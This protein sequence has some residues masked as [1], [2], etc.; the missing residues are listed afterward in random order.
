MIPV[1]V[2]MLPFGPLPVYCEGDKYNFDHDA[3]ERCY[4]ESK[5]TGERFTLQEQEDYA[6]VRIRAS[7]YAT[8]SRPTAAD[9]RAVLMGRGAAQVGCERR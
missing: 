1:L 6:S 7:R 4:E 5:R 8:P 3:M 2:T 9:K